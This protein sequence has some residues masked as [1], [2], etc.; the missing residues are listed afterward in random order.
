MGTYSRTSTC[1]PEKK[2]VK[3][4]NELFASAVRRFPERPALIEP[5]GAS[6]GDEARVTTLTHALL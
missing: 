2:D 5:T 6:G 3:T 4:L 1:S